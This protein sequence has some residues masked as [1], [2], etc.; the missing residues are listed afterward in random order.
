M[1]GGKLPTALDGVSVN[2]KAAYIEYISPTQINAVAPADSSVGP[3]EVR[4][5]SSGVT[6][7]AAI[8]TV[9][10]YAPALFTF[11][12]KYLA[13]T[14][15]NSAPLGKSGL[16]PTAPTATTPAKPGET[17]VM[18]GTG[19]GATPPAIA[20]GAATDVVV[21][22]ANP[23]KVTIG[24]VSA[25]SFFAGNITVPDSVPDGDQPVVV[26]IGGIAS[27]KSDACCLITVQR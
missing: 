13:A 11:G 1:T 12:G 21:A 2:G 15:A 3:V 18:Y 19:F 26:E 10:A 24:A 20:A 5:T 25:N 22:L 9:H 27:S 16:F 8:A 14:H 4:V 7:D 6:S 23:L 17:V